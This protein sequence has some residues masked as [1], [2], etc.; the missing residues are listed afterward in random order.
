MIPL[1]HLLLLLCDIHFCVWCLQT[2]FDGLAWH[3]DCEAKFELYCDLYIMTHVDGMLVF[4]DMTSVMSSGCASQT[5][6]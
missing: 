6:V 4:L 1:A 3:A 5:L 2:K